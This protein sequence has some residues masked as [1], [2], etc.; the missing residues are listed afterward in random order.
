MNEV[1]LDGVVICPELV[2]FV[3]AMQVQIDNNTHKDSGRTRGWKEKS[4]LMGVH[5]LG[6]EYRDL[7]IAVDHTN[8][9]LGG[10]PSNAPT[11]ERLLKEAVD[12]ANHAMHLADQCGAIETH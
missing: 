12:V 4:P 8:R 3:K 10:D 1:V 9:P 6:E 11:R 7:V 2:K 5:E